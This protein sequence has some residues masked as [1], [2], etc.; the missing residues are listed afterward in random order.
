MKAEITTDGKRILARIPYANG[1]GPRWARAV[2]GGRWAPSTKTWNYPLDM[3]TCREFRKVF[4]K[5]LTVLPALSAWARDAILR[6]TSLEE[7]RY[8]LSDIDLS[9]IEW[10]AP[11]LHKALLNRP[12]QP[13]GVGFIVEGKQVILGDEPGLGKTLQTLGALVQSDSKMILVLCKRTATRAVWERE[14][15]RWTPGIAT[16]VAQGTR[17][18]RE[19]AMNSFADHPV[20]IEGTRKM[21]II[22]LEMMRSKKVEI[23]PDAPD[24]HIDFCPEKISG[25]HDASHK[26][27]YLS[28]PEWPFLFDIT[29]DAIVMDESHNALASTKNVQSKGITQIRYGAVQLRKS[30]Y[31]GGLAVAL[32]GTPFRSKLSR[33]W[34]TLN[35]LRPD[36]FGSYWKFAERYFGVE[37]DGWGNVVG[38]EPLDQEEF[39]KV[40]R[41]YYLVR[42]KGEVAP[43]LPPIVYAGTPPEDNPEGPNYVR[44]DMDPKQE[45]AYKEMQEMASATIDG[46]KI[47]ATG[48]LA[49]IT[50][51]RQFAN[52]HGRLSG[53]SVL[54]DNPSNKMEWILD[55]LREREGT[56][57]KVVI[58]SM[59]TEMVE[60][61]ARE[62]KADKDITSLV[63]T[64]TGK[65]SDRARDDIV[66]QF[67]NNPDFRVVVLNAKAGGE[68]ITLDAADEM[69]IV[70][71]PWISD[72]EEQL[73]ARIHRVSRIHNVTVY[74]LASNGTVDEWMAS[75]TEDQRRILLSAKPADLRK[76]I[77]EALS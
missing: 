39:D 76:Q 68:S 24:G 37:S 41:P 16:F 67:Q 58:A 70:D 8:N 49:E 5:E 74:R 9:R 65:T 27:K 13:S 36:V 35:W 20:I 29:W 75:L 14:T 61:I 23:C 72:D 40:L 43:D 42:K 44:L 4:G 45:K 52:A 34:G 12:Y 1:S 32:S 48:V 17:A 47:M 56:G 53:G 19:Q 64:L 3:Y 22:N 73:T 31:P 46:G 7:M 69:I 51:L 55:F 26:H 21:L 59:F 66:D 18:E 30:L 62:I 38:K 2:P 10:E 77:L 54:P 57:A 11:D 33:S 6:E 71:E 50:R 25:I 60:F 63:Y 15:Q 28:F